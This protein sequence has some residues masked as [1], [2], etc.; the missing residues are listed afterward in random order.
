MP[1][2]H[3]LGYLLG[4]SALATALAWL[5]PARWQSWGIVACG[6]GLLASV[7]PL[8]L[9]LLATGTVLTFLAHRQAAGNR[10][11]VAFVTCAIVATFVAFTLYGDPNGTGIGAARVLPIGLA[12][13]S[14]RLVHYMLESY[15][16]G[17]R[18]HAL[19]EYL[20]YQLLPSALPVGPI[21][22]FDEFLRDLRRRRW[23]PDQFSGGLQRILHG[24]AKIVVLGNYL[25]GEKLALALAGSTA[26]PGLEGVYV[27]AL[28]FWTRLYIL[29]SGYSDIAIG[30]AA[31]M[32]FR[33]RE[34][35]HWPFLARNINAFWRRWH[36]SLSSWCRDYVFTPVLSL[37]RSHLFAALA[38]MIVLGL[39]HEPSL[40]Y[41]LWGGY[42]GLGIA[43]HRLFAERV[44]PWILRWPV[45]LQRLWTVV[46][47]LLTIHF[48]LFSFHITR[49]FERGLLG[50]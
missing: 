13:Y 45:A 38:A 2:L 23:D 1:E 5:L 27:G 19:G 4:W 25:V 14:L 36:L 29:F 49:L 33:L 9:G 21:H 50:N 3:L 8:S 26:Q 34:N 7:S 44:G 37:T 12:F 6:V 31:L 24:L 47:T 30:F 43:A 20:C 17:L 15:K 42:H 35:F 22:R 16:G 48:V 18:P 32:G 10:G 40:R 11:V 46:A 41:L 28:L 39:W